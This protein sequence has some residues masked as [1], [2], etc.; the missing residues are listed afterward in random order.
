[1]IYGNQQVPDP[2]VRPGHPHL[3][4]SPYDREQVTNVTPARQRGRFGW[5]RGVLPLIGF[6]LLFFGGSYL[7]SPEPDIELEPGFVVGQID[8]RDVVFVP[9]ERSG[10]RGMFQLM[11]QDMFQSRIAAIDMV[12]G[13][14][15]WDT[16]IVGEMLSEGRVIAAGRQYVYIATQEG[17]TILESADGAVAAVPDAIT[18]LT[19]GYVAEAG[20]YGF[21][22][23]AE[24]VVAIDRDGVF[25]VIEL[26]GLTATP[27]DAA[28]T[29]RWTG[30]LSGSGGHWTVSG[31]SD[32]Y[33][34]NGPEEL[35]RLNPA[36]PGAL[37][38]VLTR[39]S[40]SGETTQIG[41][42]VF[43]DGKL[44]IDQTDLA[45]DGQLVREALS[46]GWERHEDYHSEIQNAGKVAGAAADVVL[47]EHVR[48]VGDDVQLLSTVSLETGEVIDTI[49]TGSSSGRS[50]CLESGEVILPV[51]LPD[52]WSP[53]ALALI[54]Q[55]G[56]IT[57]ADVGSVGFFGF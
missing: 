47:I 56:A 38:S 54:D 5:V 9:Y 34:F 50:I 2:P 24:A 30:V 23:D 26:D 46:G 21:D 10:S 28:I 18:G 57:V 37:G 20:A 33:G 11:T 45:V 29:D 19:D 48:G 39:T 35:V 8:G 51:S 17:L 36:R 16:K 22:A 6:A 15:L 55:Q 4:T 27:A 49:E 1:M 44:V 43:Y 31:K 7:V 32:T 25:H 3:V 40:I 41:E 14:T 52:N 13:D 53:H 12:T 42:A